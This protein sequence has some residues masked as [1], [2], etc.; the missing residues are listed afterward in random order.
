MPPLR[1]ICARLVLLLGCSLCV[2]APS[3][4]QVLT[5]GAHEITELRFDGRAF[6]AA[7]DGP[8]GPRVASAAFTAFGRRFD[9]ALE[10][11]ERLIANLDATQRAALKD[12]ELFRGTVAGVDGSWVRLTRT[13]GRVTGL[14][15]DGAELY[16]ID[17]QRDLA[18]FLAT[19][20]GDPDATVIY[21]WSDVAGELGDAALPAAALASLAAAAPG[22]LPGELGVEAASLNP[23]KLLDI[24]I[25]GD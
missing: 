9:L 21:R 16:G 20:G 7:V 2:C 8:R 11:N 22:E 15:W 6:A 17:A 10:S 4:A 5:I 13:G 23:G 25:V 12:V 1:A 19:A 14:L 18:P 3:A 24:G